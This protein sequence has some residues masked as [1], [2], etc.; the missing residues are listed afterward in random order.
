[1]SPAQ[2]NPVLLAR[3]VAGIPDSKN[4]R[5]FQQRC[6][7]TSHLTTLQLVHFLTSRDIGIK[8]GNS[9]R[10]SQGDKLKLLLLALSYGCRPEILSSKLNWKDFELFTSSMLEKN[11]YKSEHN[12]RF[13]KPTIQID[14]VA[15]K[16]RDCLII[17]CKHWRVMT[18]T[19]MSRCANTQLRRAKIYSA[20]TK[21]P[22]KVFPII[23]TLNEFYFKVIDGVA[24]VPISKLGGFLQNDQF[25]HQEISDVSTTYVLTSRSEELKATD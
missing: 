14:I 6:G 4:I 5:E 13:T 22:S 19:A 10:F 23:V 11:Q 20:K 2:I 9:I 12:V 24:Y 7:I 21:T 3:G 8:S 25:F 15:K 17:D 18:Y 16:G 1:M